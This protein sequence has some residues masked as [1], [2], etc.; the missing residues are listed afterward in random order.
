[1]EIKLDM[2]ELQYFEVN[3]NDDGT[4]RCK[5]KSIPKTKKTRYGSDKTISV[6]EIPRFSIKNNNIVIEAFVSQ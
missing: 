2:S 4:F 6:Y 5:F 1:M 3:R